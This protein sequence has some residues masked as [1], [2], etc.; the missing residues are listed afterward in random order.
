[1]NYRIEVFGWNGWA[2]A[3][4]AFL[5]ATYELASQALQDSVLPLNPQAWRILAARV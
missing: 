3:L 5:F 2:R 4:P 1:M